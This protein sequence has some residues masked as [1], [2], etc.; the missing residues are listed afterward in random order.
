MTITEP[1]SHTPDHLGLISEFAGIGA[2]VNTDSRG[3][4]ARAFFARFGDT[5]GW[6]QASLSEQLGAQPGCGRFVAWLSSPGDYMPALTLWGHPEGRPSPSRDSSQAE[7]PTD[8]HAAQ[9]EA[10]RDT[11]PA[12]TGKVA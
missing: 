5:T 4:A 1:A 3:R 2:A 7:S 10:A 9:A 11:R 12:A 6:Q 8:R